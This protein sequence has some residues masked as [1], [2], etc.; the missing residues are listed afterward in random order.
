MITREFQ[1]AEDKVLGVED[2]D[3]FYGTELEQIYLTGDFGVK[4]KFIGND[5]FETV[6]HR[7]SPGF[8]ITAEKKKTGGDLLADGYCFFSGTLKL[9][10][11]V[12]LPEIRE[13]ERVYLNIGGFESVLSEI[14][15]NGR[16]A[17]N[18]AWKPYSLDITEYIWKGENRIVIALTNSLRN[19]LGEIHFVPVGDQKFTSQWSL[20]VSPRLADGPDWYL[21]RTGG[22]LKTWSDD[23]FFRPFGISKAS[24]YCQKTL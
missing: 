2:L 5:E 20:K 21:N 9:L 17:G 8:T 24:L 1:P 14:E 15:I 6:R 13:D 19:L 3:R 4:G 11:D 22:K 16:I 12:T 7:Y 10:A 18:I 23:Y